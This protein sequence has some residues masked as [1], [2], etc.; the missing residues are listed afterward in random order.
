MQNGAP[1]TLEQ[2]MSNS[3]ELYFMSF[4]NKLCHFSRDTPH[5]AVLVWEI[6]SFS[7]FYTLHISFL[8][9]GASNTIKS[10]KFL[11]VSNF[12]ASQGKLVITSKEKLIGFDVRGFTLCFL[13]VNHLET[14]NLIASIKN[15]FIF[16]LATS[17]LSQNFLY[18]C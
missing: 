15:C 12:I 1:K 11:F 16:S 3:T 9:V 10:I 13:L 6:L 18:K 17:T 14:V 7:I 5:L 2:M 8:S 4:F